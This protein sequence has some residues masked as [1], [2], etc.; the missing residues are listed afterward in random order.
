MTDTASG[1]R[2]ARRTVFFPPEQATTTAEPV[3]QPLNAAERFASWIRFKWLR[4]I[5]AT[6]T[7][8]VFRGEEAETGN[9]VTVELLSEKAARDA[10]Q[11]RLFYLE[12][13]AASRLRHPQI[14]RA[15]AA[16]PFASSHLRRARHLPGSESLRDRL[17]REGWLEPAHALLII[18]QTAEA[19]A[20]AHQAGV[21]HLNLQPEHIWIDRFD[22][23][24]ITGF[25]IADEKHL[26]WARRKR[27]PACAP[28]YISPEQ[29]D[30]QAGTRAGDLYAL[31][32][33]FY[34]LLT[35]RVPFDSNDFDEVRQRHKTSAPRAP[36]ELR[37]ELSPALSETVMA[38]LHRDPKVRL[39]KFAETNKL[40]SLKN[41]G[42]ALACTQPP[43][44]KVRPETQAPRMTNPM[45]LSELAAAVS[46]SPAA[47]A[48]RSPGS[49]NSRQPFPSALLG[50]L[51]RSRRFYW[52]GLALLVVA[53]LSW[54]F[55]PAL[56]NYFDKRGAKSTPAS[57]QINRR[58]ST[59]NAAAQ[60]VPALTQQSV[61]G[62][63]QTTSPIAP[64][65]LPSIEGTPKAGAF[66]F[67]VAIKRISPVYPRYARRAVGEVVVD[68]LVNERGN[69]TQ[70]RVVS[71]LKVFRASALT[72]ARQWKF[73]PTTFNG[74]PVKTHRMIAFHYVPPES[75]PAT[76]TRQSTEPRPPAAK[77]KTG[78]RFL[79]PFRRLARPFTK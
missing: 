56:Q 67:G 1:A 75:S 5:A 72:A 9:A 22:R 41:V 61:A 7:V 29:F 27:M 74:A 77:P 14:A 13:E 43:Q 10:E 38:M 45:P 49:P 59:P 32:V 65:N 52:A 11:V 73:S 12:A 37:P 8:T 36:H 46:T 69:V 63:S 20:Q 25:G 53:G 21:L 23:V 57:E 26:D 3:P 50:L 70:A 64:L 39:R 44:A 66:D 62:A 34:E 68:V 40:A 30:G 78:N 15:Y 42:Q 35:D 4:E 19:I 24:F 71:G 54:F 47:A 76:P 28:P 55:L 31:G 33:I 60:T 6:P 58:D 51:E 18:A 79:R 17:I 2:Q 48:F 16:E